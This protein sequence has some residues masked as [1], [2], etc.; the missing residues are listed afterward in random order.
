[1]NKEQQE[2]HIIQ[3]REEISGVTLSLGTDRGLDA[4]NDYVLLLALFENLTSLAAKNSK[5]NLQRVNSK[6]NY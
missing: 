4:E 6:E 3:P 2:T 1:L 5:E